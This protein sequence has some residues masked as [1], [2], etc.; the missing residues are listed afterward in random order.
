[1]NPDTM[2]ADIEISGGNGF[3]TIYAESDGA[4]EWVAEKVHFESWQ[5]NP[6]DGI[7]LDDTRMAKDIADGAFKDGLNVTVNGRKYLGDNRAE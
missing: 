5:G 7:S 1:M 2:N 4:K 6:T 3:Y